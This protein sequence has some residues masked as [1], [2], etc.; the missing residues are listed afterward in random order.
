MK[1]FRTVVCMALL[2][3]S[4]L[5][6]KAQLSGI[7]TVPGSY[8]TIAAAITD[9]NSAGVAGGVTINI[10]AGHTE[11]VATGGLS[12]T[13]TGTS[14]NPIIF[15]K[16]GVGA[17]P[18]LTAYTGGTATPAT[19]QQDGVWRLIGSD[20]VTIDG[21]DIADPNTTNPATMEF[22]YGM[23]KAGATDGCQY[24]TIKNCV[25]T[26][27]R[28]NNAAGAGPSI[29]GSKGI[30]VINAA[31]GTNTTNITVTSTSGAHSYNRIYSNT[32]QNCNM[33]IVI[34]GYNASSPFTLRDMGNDIGGSS[35]LTGNT[36]I[37]YGGGGSNI[38]DGIHVQYQDDLNISFNLINSNNGTGA[39]HAGALR[40]INLSASTSAN[41]S[42][43]N[44]TVTLRP[45]GTTQAVTGI[46]NASGST[47][48]SNTISINNNVIRNCTYT[49]ATSGAFNGILNS[50]TPA[51]LNIVGNALTNCTLSGTGAFTGINGA[52]AISV[53]ITMNSNTVTGNVK[54][55]ASGSFF[56]MR[57]GTSSITVNGNLISN[58]GF[59]GNSGASAS[60]LYGIYNIGAPTNE[61]YSNNT[62]TT[63][64]ISGASTATTHLIYGIYANTSSSSFKTIASN[65]IGGLVMAT[66]LAGGNAFG[67]YNALSNTAEISKN[68]IYD[69]STGGAAANSY[70]I[71][72]NSG[73][74]TNISNN[75]LGDIK[76]PAATASLAIAGI[77]I[78]AG[79]TANLYY[80]TVVLNAGSTGSGFGTTAL[81]SP[82][83]TAITLRNNLFANLSTSTGTGMVTALRSN[84]SSLTNYN[85]ASN[86]N[87][88]YAGIPGA[89]NLIFYDGTNSVPT[90]SA[91]Q[92]AVTP[93]E[94]NS[95][96]E[97]PPLLSLAGSSPNFLH[98]DPTVP[99]LLESGGL[100]ISG[101]TDDADGQVRQGNPGYSGTGTAPD[102]GA[103]EFQ[104]NTPLCSGVVSSTVSALS[105]TACAGQTLALY[106][107]GYSIGSG[108]TY[109]WKVAAV[110]G[111]PYTNVADPNSVHHAYA[112]ASHSAGVHYFVMETTCSAGPLTAVSNEISFTVSPTPVASIS[113]PSVICAGLNLNLNG[114]S[115]LGTSY[116]WSG[117]GSFSSASQNTMVPAVT[118]AASGDYS[119]V[120]SLDGCSSIP[121]VKSV[122]VSEISLSL[123][124]TSP[125]LCAGSSATITASTSALTYTWSTASNASSIVVSP[126]LN[127][128]YSVSVTNNYS[129]TADAS[130]TIGVVDVTIAPVHAAGCINETATL[131]VNAY[132]PSVVN[133]YA[134]PTST[135]SLGTGT[136]FT[137]SAIS[138]TVLYAEAYSGKNDSLFTNVSGT[139]AFMGE[140]FDVVALKTVIV[141]GFDA[142][143]NTGSGTIEIWYRPGTHVGFTT[144]NS[145]WTLA[146]SSTLTS[147]GN[148]AITPIPATLA[149]TIPAGQT[150]AFYI[151]AN[152]G[153]NVRYS[154][155][156]SLGA[157][158]AQ[159]S[160]IQILQGSTGNIYFS[161]T[162]SPR[163]F[164]GTVRYEV[165][166]CTS[167]RAAVNLTVNNSPVIN[168][169]ASASSV[170]YSTQATFTASGASTYTWVNGPASATYSVY[171]VSA[172]VYTV[173]GTSAA[174]CTASTSVSLGVD[175]LPVISI[176][177]SS[178]TV[179]AFEPVTLTASGASTYIWNGASP[180]AVFNDAPAVSAVYSVTG[181]NSQGCVASETV[182]VTT[183]SL[184]VIAV[185]PTS[186]VVCALSPVSFTAT[187]A[188]TY[189]WN[190]T[191][192]GDIFTDSPSGNAT[193]TVEGTSADGCSA[194]ETVA[195]QTNSLP[196]VTIIASEDT[197][198]A[199]APVTFTAFGADTYLWDNQAITDTVTYFPAT[200][201]SYTV[202]G[203]NSAG[204]SAQ[205]VIAVTTNSLPALTVS[206]LS[207]SV[208]AFSPVTFTAAGA[209]L[210]NWNGV[211]GSS[212]FSA[213][214]SANATYTVVGTSAESCTSSSV[215]SVHVYNL[216]AVTISSSS[217]TICVNESAELTAGGATQFNWLPDNQTTAIIT[218]SPQSTTVYTV[219]G[220]DNNSCVNSATFELV[221][222]LCTGLVQ[223]KNSA[224]GIKVFPNPGN[225]Y[226]TA[227][228]T[229]AAEREILVFNTL[230]QQALKMSCT[231]NVQVI[232][233]SNFAR[234]VYHITI[235]TGHSAATF[236]VIV[237]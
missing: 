91:Y 10:A 145:G 228:F 116:S 22:G 161:V 186:A 74:T 157:V 95:F 17:N 176:S 199:M 127:T 76:T 136:D 140:M 112:S 237:E 66:S 26:L 135:T 78:N 132:S 205:A 159:N 63:L 143:F 8:S 154:T 133:W 13:A 60:S 236:R 70:G 15:Q 31:T 170:C 14:A 158:Y 208:C 101:I 172:A 131:S 210:Y 123:S 38:S 216:P 52:G 33:G 106:S 230:G 147:N 23:Y 153:P 107:A 64:T 59:S 224:D 7:Y 80:N 130:Y 206:P 185:S 30:S 197:V 79:T 184:P 203:T 43:S 160:E 21:I 151:V 128:V 58:N 193:Y 119:L 235:K 98:I 188:G 92:T 171:P 85:V 190:N 178:A 41:A 162:T 54:S 72:V 20:Y 25:I 227:N 44:N 215:V 111:G 194:T 19:E 126:A 175:P 102:V 36:I 24:N 174:G 50:G 225:G 75:L 212:T 86:H 9:L 231:G 177:P 144:S 141:T 87:A 142:H 88:F 81:Y 93:R 65:T 204:C 148:S 113:A 4:V 12:L 183:N 89:S 11:T 181:T 2:M 105:L 201:N 122:T 118:S 40:G 211:S 100:N 115:D 114:S 191:F 56:C 5:I 27:R 232:D 47:A 97:N 35:M 156:T 163:A 195:V 189:T 32:I 168:I 192:T 233:L 55:G 226:L 83:A 229:T 77:Y 61:V 71:W 196:V 108:I 121:A 125:E 104:S 164:N 67:I 18:L 146:S 28:A 149:I 152:T 173:E 34:I 82:T 166:G 42:V 51:F 182:A 39:N 223:N 218:V 187:G 180:G 217:E 134:S 45:G 90:F 129:C 222:D 207:Q 209:V 150:Y 137:M 202:T 167:P 138:N 155:G 234:G 49:T 3:S 62:I 99:T 68:K 1:S 94:I 16:S 120:A 179:C 103:D 117:P 219:T 53:S 213:A 165:P 37:N 109:Q 214:P 73:G 48:A 221:V 29:E 110:A 198:C 96:T 69:I 169:A 57:A 46:Q 6:S 200:N 84:G 139:S 124:S 220:T